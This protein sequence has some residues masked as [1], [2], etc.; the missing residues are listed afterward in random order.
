MNIALDYL[1]TNNDGKIRPEDCPQL[2]IALFS[3]LQATHHKGSITRDSMNQ[4]MMI[5]SE[6]IGQSYQKMKELEKNNPSSGH[7]S[8]EELKMIRHQYEQDRS[9]LRTLNLYFHNY[10]VQH[11]FN[12]LNEDVKQES[13]DIGF[14]QQQLNQVER[15]AALISDPMNDH[16]GSD[17]QKIQETMN[18]VNI[19]QTNTNI[20]K[21]DN[22]L[23]HSQT[24]QS[25]VLAAQGA[26]AGGQ[27]RK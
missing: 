27:T 21:V 1:D 3:L 10:F 18:S 24:D 15:Q 20:M 6:K 19:H 25:G 8:N 22:V 4:G 5:L 23:A 7:V 2:S 14:L 12:A 13:I 16:Q 26:G 17:I 11:I 9:S